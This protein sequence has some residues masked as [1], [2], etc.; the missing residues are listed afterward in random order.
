MYI[1]A[2]VL[3]T[4]RLGEALEAAGVVR[5]SRVNNV[6]ISNWTFVQF[7]LFEPPELVE[8]KRSSGY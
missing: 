2:G 3:R 4:L 8:F 5:K 6:S 7:D 1:M